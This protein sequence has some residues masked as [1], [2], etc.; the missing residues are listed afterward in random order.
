MMQWSRQLE[1]DCS[2]L[3]IED[4]APGDKLLVSI[5]RIASICQQVADTRRQLSDDNSVHGTLH[6][7]PFLSSLDQLCHTFSD[8]LSNHCKRVSL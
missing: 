1:Q 5:A 3:V 4:E 2:R 6:I 8:E 7:T